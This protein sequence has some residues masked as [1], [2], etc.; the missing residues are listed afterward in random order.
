V[1][2][3]Q[4]GEV[5][6]RR[7]PTL[8]TIGWHGVGSVRGVQ[9]AISGYGPGVKMQKVMM[10]DMSMPARPFPPPCSSFLPDVAVGKARMGE[11]MSLRSDGGAP[12]DMDL[13][14]E[15]LSLQRVD[16][17]FDLD[18]AMLER[19]GIEPADVAA[20][21]KAVPGDRN[22][23]RRALHTAIVLAVLE[24]RFADERGT[25]FAAVR[26]SR[27][28]LKKTAGGWGPVVNGKTLDQWAKEAAV[29]ASA[30]TGA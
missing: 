18:E 11:V 5:V 17:G 4:T 2:D 13:L 7:V 23:A 9:A 26:K 16:G 30:A 28:W 14:M 12:T 19:L 10:A 29:A 21:A 6:L 15:L 27:T 1:K 25:W 22:A 20:A 3:K 24:T 8:V